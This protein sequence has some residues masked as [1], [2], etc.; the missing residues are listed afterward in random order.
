MKSVAKTLNLNAI[1]TNVF[2]CH[3]NV[4]MMKI[5]EMVQ[6]NNNS[7]VVSRVHLPTTCHHGFTSSHLI[8]EVTH[9]WTGSLPGLVR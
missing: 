9:G 2:Q 8:I 1:I 3:G 7:C 6:M 5:V 4:T